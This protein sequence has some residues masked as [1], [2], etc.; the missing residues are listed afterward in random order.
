MEQFFEPTAITYRL[1]EL[2]FEILFE[3]FIKNVDQPQ[4]CV[5]RKRVHCLFKNKNM[6]VVQSTHHYLVAINGYTYL[7]KITANVCRFV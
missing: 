6:Y 1:E 3:E 4:T 7:I 2:K 5:G